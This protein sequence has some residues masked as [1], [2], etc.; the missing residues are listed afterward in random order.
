MEQKVLFAGS[1]DPITLGHVDLI[2]RAANVFDHVY[3]AIAHNSEKQSY[4]SLE[5]KL[6]L[7]KEA[8]S[9]ISG[10][11]VI[12]SPQGLTVDLAK[13]LDCQVLLRGIRNAQDLE[14]EAGIEA[15]NKELAPNIE[16][17]F[18]LSDPKYRY[19]SSG[20]VKAV[21]TAGGNIER[22]VP[23]NVYQALKSKQNQSN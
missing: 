2:K 17:V 6:S 18:L 9:S 21:F 8:L 14:Y 16:T 10:V 11:E 22:L 4:F 7:V 23:N 3:V 19:L 13:K 20:M 15:I 1:F 5:E 12:V